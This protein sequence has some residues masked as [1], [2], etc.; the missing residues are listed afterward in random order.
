MEQ[1]LDIP[2]IPSRATEQQEE[3]ATHAPEAAKANPMRKIM[4]LVG[5]AIIVFLGVTGYSVQKSIQSSGQLADIKDLYFPVLQRIDVNI[6]RLDKM[7]EL[8]TRSVMLGDRETLGEARDVYRQAD[9]VFDELAGLYPARQAEVNK[10][11]GDLKQYNTLALATAEALLNHVANSPEQTKQMNKVLADLRESIKAFRESSYQNFVQTLAGTQ[12]AVTVNLYMGVALGMM[13]LFFMGVLVYFIRNNVTMMSV[14][15]EQNSTLERRVSERTTQ[16]RQKTHDIQAML[17][18]MPQGVMTVLAG[19]VIHPE[20]SAYLETIFETDNIAGT[21]L[22]NMVFAGTSLGSDALSQ[23]DAAVGSCIG[24]DLMNFEFNAHLLAAEFDKTMPDGRVKSLE[25]SWSPIAD[26]NDVVDK[27]MLCVR[28]VTELKRLSSAAGAQARELE[29]IGEILAVSQEKFQEFIESSRKFVA[30][31]EAVIRKTAQRDGEAIDLLFR[32]M[33]TIKGNA[34]TYGLL[35][36]TNLV[37]E[38]EQ[39]YQELRAD[40]AKTWEPDALL[41]QLSQVSALV[42]EF[43]KINDTTLG[44]KG[45][46]RRGNVERFLMVEKDQV[47]YALDLIKSIDASDMA[48]MHAAVAEIGQVLSLIGT[49]KVDRVLV[50]IIESLP[51]LAKELGKEPPKVTVSTNGILVR[52]HVV[53]L[54]KNVFTHVFRNS[55]DHG[56][57]TAEVRKRKGKAAAGSIDLTLS[58]QGDRLQLVLRDD[59]AGLAIGKIREKAIHGGLLKE[60]DVSPAEAVAQ[61]ILAAGFSTADKISEVSGRG[62]GMDAVKG[63]LAAE[64]GDVSI[65]LT[66]SDSHSDMRPFELV[67]SLPDKFAFRVGASSQVAASNSGG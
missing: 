53:G 32:N 25:L 26:D 12:Q 48:A 29:I 49:E 43:Q 55:I 19:G 31:N 52:N 58:L 18:N 46:G 60:G 64:G 47:S 50:G 27:L 22:M 35:H 24:E 34:R 15:A 61:L 3:A 28:D 65:R 56:L 5:V 41:A 20:Y 10:L 63:F 13:N 21:N 7:E 1:T 59:G 45:P 44:R 8:F 9:K 57:E 6:V 66:D 11:R 40:P 62:V 42:D 30:E 67:M 4:L 33:H 51:S 39:V 16:L 36:M 54:L 38:T 14:I 37:H 2:L 23:V 17:Q